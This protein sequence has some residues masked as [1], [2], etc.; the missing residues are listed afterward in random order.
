MIVPRLHFLCKRRCHPVSSTSPPIC[1]RTCTP[2]AEW[3]IL[4]WTLLASANV[5]NSKKGTM[6]TTTTTARYIWQ[7][8]LTKPTLVTYEMQ[9][10]SK[11]GDHSFITLVSLAWKLCHSDLHPIKAMPSMG[12]DTNLMPNISDCQINLLGTKTPSFWWQKNSKDEK[13]IYL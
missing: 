6:T 12:T 9:C 8:E 3:I 2:P 7:A 13:R 1:S 11:S 10:S 5:E 4:G